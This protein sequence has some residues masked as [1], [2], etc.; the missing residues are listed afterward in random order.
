M[1]GKKTMDIL[2]RGVTETIGFFKF[3][4]KSQSEDALQY[5]RREV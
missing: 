1:N 3:P 5:A 4:E 2:L